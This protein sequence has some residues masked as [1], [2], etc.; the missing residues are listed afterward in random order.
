MYL[1]RLSTDKKNCVPELSLIIKKKPMP[2][3]DIYLPLSIQQIAELIKQLPKNR[4]KQL[5]NL[6]LEEEDD[7]VLDEHKEIV[8]KRIQK[9]KAQPHKLVDEEEAWKDINSAG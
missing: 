2:S 3:T 8:R 4:K 6:L 1:V 5:V 7:A 9:Y